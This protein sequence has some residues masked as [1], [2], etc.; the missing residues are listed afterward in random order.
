M[1]SPYRASAKMVLTCLLAGALI[2]CT[3]MTPKREDPLIGKIVDSSNEGEISYLQLLEQATHS[4]VIY[5][6]ENH[7]NA[8]HHEIQLKIIRDLIEAGKKPQLGFEFFS[9]EQTGY[10]TA[11]VR[12]SSN[13]MHKLPEDKLEGKLRRELGWQDRPDKTWLFYFRF[14]QLARKHQ[15]TVFGADLPAGTVRSISRNGI[16][17]LSPVEKSLLQPTGYKN[18]AYKKLMFEKFKAAHCGF[19]MKNHQERM[20]ET[21]L[22][23]NDTMSRSIT[24]MAEANPK[25]PVIVILGGGH[26]QHNMG[27][28]ERTGHLLPDVRQL[29]IGLTEIF[30]QEAPLEAYLQHETI[31]G[32]RFQPAHEYL[33]FTQRSSYKDP[34]KRFRKHLEAM[35]QSGKR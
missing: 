9:I 23:R 1:K 25:Q 31:D 15:L 26:T 12:R 8:D 11:Y 19:A 34:C 22:A 17:G 3:T 21:W 16:D 7:E 6:G 32:Q 5:L 2:N 4:D 29:N 10:L 33:W 24:A 27:V 13:R 18:K 35:K 14:M 20:Y 28:F 30:R